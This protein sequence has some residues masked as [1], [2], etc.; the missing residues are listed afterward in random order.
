MTQ[1]QLEESRGL[2][3]TSTSHLVIGDFNFGDE[4]E[5]ETTN[6]RSFKDAWKEVSP[7]LSKE[8]EFS[9]EEEWNEFM[10]GFTYDPKTNTLANLT[11]LK[12]QR[13][14]LDRVSTGT[15]YNV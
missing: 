3:I 11:S 12:K 1:L 14:R 13:R 7:K 9:T 10:S 15:K 5:N 8:K 6:F 4:P 2:N